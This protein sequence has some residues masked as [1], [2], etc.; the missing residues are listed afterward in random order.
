MTRPTSH[1]LRPAQR[2]TSPLAAHI[3]GVAGDDPRE[4]R[5]SGTHGELPM[6]QLL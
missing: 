3:V 2:K 1:I 5:C 4:R 6:K